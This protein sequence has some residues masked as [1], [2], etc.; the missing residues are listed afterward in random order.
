MFLQR[1]PLRIRT[2]EVGSAIPR[3]DWIYYSFTCILIGHILPNL[4]V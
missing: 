3:R 1:N 2:M 4:T